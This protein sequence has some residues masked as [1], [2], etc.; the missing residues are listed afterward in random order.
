MALNIFDNIWK[1]PFLSWGTN[2]SQGFWMSQQTTM[3]QQPNPKPTL[4]KDEEQVYNQMLSD[5]LPEQEAIGIIK[6]R[7]SDLLEGNTQL[8][9]VEV[10]SLKQ[11]QAD[12]LW[13]DEAS[14]LLK[15][16]RTD[17]KAQK[18]TEFNSAY[19]K[20]NLA[21]KGAYN[22]L[23]L[24]AGNLETGLKYTGNVLDFLTFGKLGFGEDVKQMEQVTQSPEFDS[25]A[26]KIGSYLPDM[27]LWVS[28]IGWWYLAGAKGLWNLA[29]RSWIV[30]AWFGATTPIMDK[31]SEA[32]MWDIGQ[33]ALIWGTAWAVLPLIGSQV[34]KWYKWATKYISKTLPENLQVS[35]QFNRADLTNVSE[36]LAKLTGKE[37]EVEDAARWLLDRWVK[38]DLKTQRQQIQ[39]L[40]AKEEETASK[41]LASKTWDIWSTKEANNLRK[42]LSEKLDN[43]VDK[44]G[45]PTAW[46]EDI[47]AKINALVN[48]P[49]MTLQ[50]MNNWR[51][52]LADGLFNK[53]WTMKE[54]ASK[55]GW[56]N[57]WKETSQFIENKA[58]W[59]RA[60]NKNIEVGIAI[61][62]AMLKKE[63]S[64][65]TKQMLAYLGFGGW[66]GWAWGYAM[67]WDLESAVKWAAVWFWIWQLSRILN[68]PWVK[69][70]LAYYLN[71][72]SPEARATMRNLQKGIE[73]KPEDIGKVVEE[74][75]LLPA[76]SGKP[77]SIL[78]TKWEVVS[79]NWI[80]PLKPA[81]SIEDAKK[82]MQSQKWLPNN[83]KNARNTSTN[84]V[85]P[86]NIESNTK[87]SV[88]TPKNSTSTSNNTSSNKARTFTS[89][90]NA[91]TSPV[92]GNKTTT[93]KKPSSTTPT[94]QSK[95][96]VSPKKKEDVAMGKK[97][98]I[99]PKTKVIEWK[100][101][102]QIQKERLSSEIDWLDTATKNRLLESRMRTYNEAVANYERTKSS[103]AKNQINQALKDVRELNPDFSKSPSPK[104]IVKNLQKTEEKIHSTEVDIKNKEQVAE[105]KK[106]YKEKMLKWK[107]LVI[108]SDKIK[109]FFTDYNPKNPSTVHEPSS[110]LAKEFYGIA[111]KNPTYKKVVLTAG[112]GWS[113]KSEILVNGIPNDSATLVFDWTGKSY[114]KIVSQYDEAIKAGKEAEINAVYIDYNKAKKFN[115]KRER[116]VPESI[117]ADTHSGYRKTILQIAK[118][119][120]DININLTIN[121][122]ERYS[123]WKAITIRVP[124]Q[125][126]A[127]WIEQMQNLE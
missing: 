88:V 112:G 55:A 25:T 51:R 29:L 11:M 24:W 123:N 5:G 114:K 1:S 45:I 62:K 107:N 15:Q 103:L 125:R 64:E 56:Q 93:V 10:S 18:S 113:G 38:W 41:I 96:I 76:P 23:M 124:K 52:L 116:N 121:S 36:R 106:K 70:R 13:A 90:S 32:T 35:S 78:N 42:A 91:T 94:K 37:V 127:T 108:D 99:L 47:A 40:I 98:G 58:P 109:E 43:Y 115:A 71:K 66:V 60:T 95:G 31:G 46:N 7:R 3:A 126:I 86:S 34:A 61:D 110:Q 111:L 63:T 101:T 22:A 39:G 100:T 4:F 54:L 85:V 9:P 12:W 105:L 83:S 74:M 97:E 57:V 75:K 20:W 82:I 30:G 8:N 102:K 33:W 68:S 14:Q 19:E 118:E 119:R 6:K 49:K 122:G 87:S 48:N 73:I 84:S 92:S 80:I 21:Q 17:T 16:Y 77:V 117:L 79:N 72:L 81:Q 69:S 44:D 104:P 65:Q 26:R 50:E 2:V 53:Q 120:P 89:S 27:A 28:P 67:G 59:F